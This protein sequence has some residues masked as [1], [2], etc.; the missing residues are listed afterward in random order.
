[1]T[2]TPSAS[3]STRAS[4]DE[5]DDLSAVVVFKSRTAAAM[6][7]AAEILEAS[8]SDDDGSTASNSSTIGA[9]NTIKVQ[10]TPIEDSKSGLS[11]GEKK[12]SVETSANVSQLK[13]KYIDDRL[14]NFDKFLQ[15]APNA[16]RGKKTTG[17]PEAVTLKPQFKTCK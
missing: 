14:Q 1:V 16:R 11:D 6:A 4:D 15:S 13:A 17:L 7:A 5:E 12:G 10:P 9:D 8:S 2:P 3:A